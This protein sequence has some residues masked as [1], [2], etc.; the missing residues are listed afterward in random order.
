MA[1][2]FDAV[3]LSGHKQDAVEL[4]FDPV[5]AWN[6]KAAPI[7]RGRRGQR[8]GGMLD[9]IAFES[10]VVARQKRHFVLIEAALRR[11]AGLAAGDPVH[12]VLEPAGHP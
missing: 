4:P 2:V 8:V 9:A 5:A 10:R 1:Q 11:Q 3:L 12:V 7:A 6:S